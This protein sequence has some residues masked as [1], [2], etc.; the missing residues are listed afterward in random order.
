MEIFWP[1]LGWLY[2]IMLSKMITFKK[3]NENKNYQ[4]SIFL[5]CI[6]KT[7]FFMWNYSTS[8]PTLQN[9]RAVQGSAL[10]FVCN[11]HTMYVCLCTYVKVLSRPQFLCCATYMVVTICFAAA[12]LFG[13]VHWCQY[14]IATSLFLDLKWQ[15]SGGGN[16]G[17]RVATPTSFSIFDFY[18]MESLWFKFGYDIFTGFKMPRL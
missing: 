10:K 13:Y 16:E 5:G 1:L 6:N 12:I 2:T 17:G 9:L 14:I 4:G 8:W 18:D 15:F 3:W 7:H 11:V